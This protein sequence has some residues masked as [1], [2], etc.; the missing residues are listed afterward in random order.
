[1]RS[2][3]AERGYE[4]FYWRA[5]QGQGALHFLDGHTVTQGQG[6]LHFLNGHTV[7]QII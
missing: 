4:F 5:T 2:G 3:P 1:M 7:T 6:A